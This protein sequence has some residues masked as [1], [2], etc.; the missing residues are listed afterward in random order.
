AGDRLADRGPGAGVGGVGVHDAAHL[1]H[2][3]VHVGVRLGVAGGG[4]VALHELALEVA[5]DHAVGRELVVGH[6]A[7]LDHHQVVAGD[8]AGHVARGPDDEVV[9]DQLGVQGGDAFAQLL[10]GGL[11]GGGNRSEEHTSE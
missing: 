10:D 11:G 2:V 8:P 9:A 5:D 6:P 7:R 1:G 4:V 3:P